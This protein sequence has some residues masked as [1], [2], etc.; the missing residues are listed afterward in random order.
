[1]DSPK[2]LTLQAPT[3]RNQR[4]LVWLQS[5]DANRKWNRWDAV[6]VGKEAYRHWKDAGARITCRIDLDAASDDDF[7][8]LYEAAKDVSL[9]LL[10][11]TVLIRKSQAFWDENFDNVLNLNQLHESYPFLQEEWDGSAEDAVT[12]CAWLC[13]YQRL[14]DGP[15][16]VKETRQHPELQRVWNQSPPESAPHTAPNGSAQRASHSPSPAQRAGKGPQQVV[17][18]P[19]GPTI[20]FPNRLRRAVAGHPNHVRLQT[21]AF[22]H[23]IRGVAPRWGPGDRRCRFAQPPA[24]RK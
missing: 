4:T 19:N 6:V 5:Q 24:H 7:A 17:R 18:R 10:P 1:M 21:H 2:L 15:D 20:P 11:Q 23:P 12:L 3:V 16:H 22:T 8:E 13:R 14:V 9:V